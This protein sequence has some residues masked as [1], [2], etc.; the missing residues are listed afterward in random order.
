MSDLDSDSP[1]LKILLLGGIFVVV[2][3]LLV[4]VRR[5]GTWSNWFSHS[6]T[7]AQ[8]PIETCQGEIRGNINIS[9]E[10]L[11]EFLTVSE[12][13]P[14]ARVQDILQQSYCQLPA[15]EIRAGVPAERQVYPLAFHP[16]TW[17]IVLYEGEEYAGFQ[18]SFQHSED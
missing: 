3:A 2:F 14:K 6:L 17:L 11:A 4:D 15:I 10:K 9:R 16:Q 7:P 1:L 13:E 18:F 12:R 8:T 5:V